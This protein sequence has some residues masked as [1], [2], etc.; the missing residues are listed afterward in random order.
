MILPAATTA[1]HPK[2]PTAATAAMKE[3]WKPGYSSINGWAFFVGRVL[4]PNSEI[5][6]TMRAV[7]GLY[8]LLG[9]VNKLLDTLFPFLNPQCYKNLA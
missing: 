4:Y 1:L 2:D 3:C 7:E 8:L 9:S 5:L 6:T